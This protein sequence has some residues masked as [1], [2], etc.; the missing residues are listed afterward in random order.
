M[1]EKGMRVAAWTVNDIVQV[2]SNILIRSNIAFNR[3]MHLIS[4]VYRRNGWWDH[5][6]FPFS[7]TS[8]ICPIS[9][10]I[11]TNSS[12]T[13]SN[14]SSTSLFIIPRPSHFTTHAKRQ[15]LLSLLAF[16]NR[17]RFFRS[18]FCCVVKGGLVVYSSSFAIP[19]ISLSIYFTHQLV[20]NFHPYC[21]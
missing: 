6:R 15:C 20:T 13:V 10:G 8:R 18:L 1:R 7:L 9:S 12:R 11:W 2:S 5:Y 17:F 16:R 14:N 4:F 19:F 3:E 21:E